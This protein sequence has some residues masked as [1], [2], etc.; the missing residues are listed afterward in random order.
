MFGDSSNELETKLCDF[1]FATQASASS[2]KAAGSTANFA[3][4]EIRNTGR[5]SF[6]SDIFSIGMTAVQIL[7]RAQPIVTQWDW[8]KQV[9]RAMASVADAAP[10]PAAPKI[11]QLLLAA[12]DANP[13]K[14]PNAVVLLAGVAAAMKA[15]GGDPRMM[16]SAPD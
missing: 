1:G 4:P 16:P 3:A 12:V 13:A 5:G 6:M 7:S 10:C 8:S 2:S 11:K 14:R 9:E 15:A